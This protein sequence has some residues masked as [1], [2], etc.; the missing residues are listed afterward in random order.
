MKRPYSATSDAEA[1]PSRHTAA[2]IIHGVAEDDE[3][4]DE[5]EAHGG[6]PN[7]G[8]CMGGIGGGPH[9]GS[10]TMAD[11]M[12]HRDEMAG[13]EDKGDDDG[14]EL[15][16]NQ[17]SNRLAFK[18]PCDVCRKRKVSHFYHFLSPKN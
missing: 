9:A 4:E 16:L 13:G 5:D 17:A 3:L 12:R 15:I 6:Y 10:G 8:Q 7:T 14:E 2:V 1:G 11:G 18:R